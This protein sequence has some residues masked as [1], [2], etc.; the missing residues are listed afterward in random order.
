[1]KFVALFLF[2]TA[3]VIKGAPTNLYKPIIVH[4]D[5]EKQNDTY[6]FDQCFPFKNDGAN[7]NQV[8]LS[9]AAACSWYYDDACE[10]PPSATPLILIQGIN[11]SS[12]LASSPSF[13]G[14]Y[15]CQRS[16]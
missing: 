9:Y 6:E 1:M 2:S 16:V 3:M 10:G 12:A 11:H 13:K 7:I 8:E 5:G 4:Y 14:S 15:K